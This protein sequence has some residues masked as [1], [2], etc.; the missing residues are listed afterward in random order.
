MRAAV[1]RL[2]DN[3]VENI[4]VADADTDAPPREDVILVNVDDTVK[5][6]WMKD[7]N[8]FV[9]PNPFVPPVLSLAELKSRKADVL[10]AKRWEIE[11]GGTVFNGFPVGTDPESQTKYIGAVVGAQIDPNVSVKWK[12]SDGTFVQLNAQAIVG[13]AMTV[14]AHVQACFDREAVL[15]AEIDAAQTAEEL[16]AID[17]TVGWP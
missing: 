8:G 12:M 4:I 16:D 15:R 14:R 2:L 13:L 17:I 9:D 11:T 10:A 7:A 3:V 6:G 5:V 1:V